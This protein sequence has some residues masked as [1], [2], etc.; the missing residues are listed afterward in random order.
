MYECYKKTMDDDCVLCRIY[1]K[2]YNKVGE[3]DGHTN[4]QTEV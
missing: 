4:K 2:C 3:K 1:R